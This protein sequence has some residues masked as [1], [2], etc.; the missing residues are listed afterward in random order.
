PLAG[1]RRP[2]LP[3]DAR[4]DDTLRELPEGE[5]HARAADPVAFARGP[6]RRGGARATRGGLCD[7]EEIRMRRP[8]RL[9]AVSAPLACALLVLAPPAAARKF[10]MSGTWIM[11][12][13][14][15]FIPLQF[16]HPGMNGFE[17]IHAS[18]GNLTGA[19]GTPNGPIP[20][21]GG[22]TATG[23]APAT[24]RIPAHRF[25]EDAMALVPF[26][27]ITL[28]QVTTNVGI[29]APYGAATLA[30]G[31][32]RGA[33]PGARGT[34]RASRAGACSRRILPVARTPLSAASSTVRAR[35][36]SAERCSSACAAAGASR[37]CSTT[38]P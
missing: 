33:S 18:M 32:G 8:P 17:I 37:S 31:A 29:D 35:T 22:V 2:E 20:G 12:N 23:S 11:R 1:R 3:H 25:V 6:R 38:P 4:R 27:G 5:A 15:V 16:A 19:Y 34:R 9:A 30:P 21:E 36:G 7:A 14:A 26:N 24:L 13:G 10:Q 28:V